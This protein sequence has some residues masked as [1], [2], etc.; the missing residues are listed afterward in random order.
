MK[1]KTRFLL[2]LTLCLVPTGLQGAQ[3]SDPLETKIKTLTMDPNSQSPVIVLETLSDKRLLPI[4]IDVP[5]AR[6]IALELEHV[7]T[8]RPLTHD[9]IRNI[10]RELGATLRRVVITDLAN[11]TYLAILSLAF[12]G[13]EMQ[14]D[15]RPSDAIAIA[16]RMEAPIYASRQVLAKSKA[17]PAPRAGTGPLLTKLG[18]HVQDLT[19]EL[20]I[21]LDVPLQKGVL[22]ADVIKGSVAM[23]A[24]LQRGDIITRANR[25][26]IRSTKDLEGLI[27]A[28][29]SPVQIELEVIK[30]GRSSTI[31]LDLP[32]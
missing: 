23:S 30:K 9:L 16:L 20:A 29:P 15:S 4:W 27:Q 13:K 24:G 14:I 17:A 2:L 12:K 5:E 31:V 21:L 10:L 7:K 11:N 1:F 3:D 25:N 8:P 18:I 32:S 26:P 28:T 19:Q 22:V 6:S